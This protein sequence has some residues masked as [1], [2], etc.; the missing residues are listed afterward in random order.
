MPATYFDDPAVDFSD[1]T[2]ISN[3][4]YTYLEG[5]GGPG[6][7]DNT[8]PLV[9]QALGATADP[10]FHYW[11]VDADLPET[12]DEVDE[13]NNCYK[14]RIVGRTQ[15]LAGDILDVNTENY[16]MMKQYQCLGDARIWF[17]T[18]SGQFYGGEKGI[19]VIITKFNYLIPRGIKEQQKISFEF[20]WECQEQPPRVDVDWCLPEPG[21]LLDA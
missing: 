9:E 5:G 3:T 15:K 13:A 20:E 21:F 17:V 18:T 7:I 6:A 2:T 4:L 14:K 19:E 12:E 8:V 16:D 1:P 11:C 10:K